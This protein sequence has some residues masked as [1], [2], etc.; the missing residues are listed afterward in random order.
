MAAVPLV[1]VAL[2]G[3]RPWA[4]AAA[5]ANLLLASLYVIQGATA[6]LPLPDTQKRVLR[7]SHG[8]DALAEEVSRLPGPI[9]AESYQITAMLRFHRPD[10]NA[11]QWPG[12]T[13][14]S[15]YLRGRIVA[16]FGLEDIRNA[17]GFWLVSLRFVPPEIPGFRARKQRE[18]VDCGEPRLLERE[19][20]EWPC[21]RPLHV[22][23][24]YR[25]APDTPEQGPSG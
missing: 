24:I 25:Y 1:A 23:N 15:E 6:A 20:S 2:R 14:P 4:L 21:P 22:W 16:P 3:L 8:Y 18:L 13:R 5:A 11:N 17:G 19:G 10:V 9:F 7:E 12:I